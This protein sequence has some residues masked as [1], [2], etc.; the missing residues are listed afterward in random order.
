M[1]QSVSETVRSGKILVTKANRAVISVYLFE[2]YLAAVYDIEDEELVNMSSTNTIKGWASGIDE[3]IEL[4]NGNIISLGKTVSSVRYE[5]SS[6][7]TYFFDYIYVDCISPAGEVLF[8]KKVNKSAF[9]KSQR[10]VAKTPFL[11]YDYAIVDNDVFVWYSNLK[12][13][14]AGSKKI[15]AFNPSKPSNGGLY[16]CKVNEDGKLFPSL[17]ADYKSSPGVFHAASFPLE[18]G[19]IGIMRIKQKDLILGKL[20]LD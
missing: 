10:Y 20:K 18:E 15:K 4:P 2:H 14:E 16:L 19:V 7:V 3:L 6:K 8:E 5:N 12:K 9:Y 11:D 1:K 17:L 13:N